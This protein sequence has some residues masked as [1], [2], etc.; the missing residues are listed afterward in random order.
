MSQPQ[1]VF[2]FGYTHSGTSLLQNILRQHPDVFS[3]RSETAFYQFPHHYL[4]DYP[5]LDTTETV[6][7]MIL[8]CANLIVTGYRRLLSWKTESLDKDLLTT[9]ELNTIQSTLAAHPQH[10]DVFPKTFDFL[11]ERAGK[12]V[13]IEKTPDHTQQAKR[14]LAEIPHAKAIEIVRDG[15][16]ILSSKKLREKRLKEKFKSG[17]ETDQDRSL[18]VYSAYDPFWNGLAWN[19]AIHAV[20][21]ARAESGERILTIRY[22]DLTAFPEETLNRVCGFIGIEF[23]PDMLEV[24]QSNTA[25]DEK[26]AVKSGTGILS[27]SVGRYHNTL[28]RGEIALTNRLLSVGLMQHGYEL[29]SQSTV[30]RVLGILV[31]LRSLPMLIVRIWNKLK[32]RGLRYTL[33][34]LKNYVRRLIP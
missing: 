1:P 33:D 24:D 10:R 3:Q 32:Y 14:I 29:Q 20:N 19:S 26:D 15:R 5:S 17:Q 21:A 6:H 16:D 25:D 8:F 34:S 2:I 18:M 22:E 31:L 30:E 13:W 12:H 9:D 11:A 23:T 4:A 7:G 27:T 28:S